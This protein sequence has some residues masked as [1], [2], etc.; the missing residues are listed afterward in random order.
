MRYFIALIM[1]LALATSTFAAQSSTV[2]VDLTKLSDTARI[3]V[4]DQLQKEKEAEEQA[5]KIVTAAT[6]ENIEKWSNIAAGIGSAIKQLC[7]DLGV[8][9]NKFA[10]TPVGVIAMGLIFWNYA[11][12]TLLTVILTICGWLFTV[13]VTLVSARH[14]FGTTKVPLKD[15]DG[16]EY[17]V[18]IVPNYE[19]DSGEARVAS[20][21]A[22]IGMFVL[23]TIVALTTLP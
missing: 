1:V 7:I 23:A 21:V 13:I 6:P 22:H 14:F 15:E 10:Q 18:E 20:A 9:V 3:A 17:K 12:A 11:G 8:E 19:F 5:S 4:L 16:K 2:N